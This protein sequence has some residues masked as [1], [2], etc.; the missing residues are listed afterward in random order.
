MR[1][2]LWPVVAVI[3]V[4]I[5]AT[6]WAAL[7][8]VHTDSREQVYVIPQGTWAR[9][10]A[11]ENIDIL[12]SEIH[13]M[14]GVKDTLVLR[15]HDDVPQLFGPVLIMPGQTFQLPFQRAS[16]YSFAC[17]LHVSGKLDVVVAPMPEPG[18]ERLRWRADAIMQADFWRK[19]GFG[20]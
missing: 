14:V 1:R 19:G 11:G 10:S 13:L 6:A 3:G 4:A 18:W 17:S 5:V 20:V 15:N 2:Y 7:A 12:P 9:R 8:P 16:T